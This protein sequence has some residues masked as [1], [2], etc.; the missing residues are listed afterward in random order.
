MQARGA[1]KELLNL[2]DRGLRSCYNLS[3]R[4][5]II[6]LLLLMSACQ[7]DRVAEQTPPVIAD[8]PATE[9]AAPTRMEYSTVA[10]PTATVRATSR[11][12]MPVPAMPTS[13]QVASQ[14][15]E[16]AGYSVRTHPDGRLFVG[17][18]VSI[19]VIAPT[20]P[21][22]DALLKVK[23]PTTQGEQPAEAR[24]GSHG[25]GRRRQAEL[26]WAWD[27]AGLPAGHYT[28]E[29]EVTPDG[30]AWK[31]SFELLP[32]GLRSPA[33]EHARWK[34]V[35]TS[36]CR[37]SLITG[38]RAERDLDLLLPI[39]EAQAESA[40]QILNADLQDPVRIVLVPRVLGHG[41]FAGAEI[42]VSYLDRDY[43]GG[44]KA[45]VILH[46]IVHILDGR[47]GGELRPTMLVEGLAVYLSGGHYKPEALL[48]RAAALLPPEP[49]C[50]HWS[51]SAAGDTPAE[52][53]SLGRFIPLTELADRF[54]FQQHE[55]GYL[56]AGALIAFMV[57]RWGWEAFSRFYRDIHPPG[58]ALLGSRS[59]GE[60]A[61]ALDTALRKH[62]GLGLEQL[63][64]QF[65]AALRAEQ[66]SPKAA[67]DLRLSIQFYETARRYQ[68]HLDPSAHFLTAW[69]L[70]SEAMRSRDIVAD[71]LRRPSLTENLTLE[72]MLVEA[73]RQIDTGDFAEAARLIEA[74]NTVLTADP[75][76]NP[77]A[78]LSHP[79]AADYRSLVQFALDSGYQP[80]QIS[81]TNGT[82]R[83]LVST[84]GPEI[85]ELDL[86][87]T[88][89]G[90]K[91]TTASG[92]LPPFTARSPS[93]YYGG[94][95]QRTPLSTLNGDSQYRFR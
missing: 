35:E 33:E 39:I 30:P 76:N 93:S 57:D 53:C 58:P 16:A 65:R 24:F 83:M 29:F 92:M 55:T 54:Y 79:I 82:A 75:P 42:A 7:A 19:E 21:G 56:Q 69:L 23:L 78:M 85:V 26:L 48:P 47:L 20:G 32:A 72:T 4:R 45:T 34:T 37:I 6:T 27:T 13:V 51:D 90:W 25:I 63:E 15:A 61:R 89:D 44:D 94:Q 28:L 67:E 3:M 62:F 36:C 80:E 2:P 70:D 14:S 49:N 43:M 46:E 9:D 41:G 17:D 10:P 22:G 84:S 11:P 66:V 12:P 8:A 68:E 91:P 38:S 81:L 50:V 40:G 88:P 31:Q 64:V 18:L 1:Y 71:Y 52:G 5:W 60:H 87:H 95:L 77:Q 59:G 74:I 86:L 73:A